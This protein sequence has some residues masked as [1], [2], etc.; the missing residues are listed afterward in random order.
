[1]C[2]RQVAQSRSLCSLGKL[3]VGL[4]FYASVANV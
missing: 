3:T 2:L 4:V 1:M